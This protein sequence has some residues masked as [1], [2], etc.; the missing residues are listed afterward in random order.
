MYIHSKDN[1]LHT[2][3]LQ[4]NKACQFCNYNLQHKDILIIVLDS[5]VLKVQIETDKYCGRLGY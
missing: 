1:L 2:L 3:S 4:H 5:E